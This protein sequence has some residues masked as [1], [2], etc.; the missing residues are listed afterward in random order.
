MAKRLKVGLILDGLYLPAWEYGIVESIV[1]SDIAYVDLLVFVHDADLKSRARTRGALFNF[2]EKQG[3]RKTPLEPDACAIMNAQLLLASTSSIVLPSTRR[4]P[5]DDPSNTAIEAVCSRKLDVILDLYSTSGFGWPNAVSKYGIW[6]YRHG[7]RRYADNNG[8]IVGIREVL[9]RESVLFSA[10]QCR[11][12]GSA[13]EIELYA[14]HS[15][16]HPLSFVRTRN[17]HLWKCAGFVTRKLKDLSKNGRAAMTVSEPSET[18]LEQTDRQSR[19]V[20]ARNRAIALPMVRYLNWRIRERIARRRSFDQWTLMTDLTGAGDDFSKFQVLA[21]ARDRFWA[22]PHIIVR[23]SVYYIFFEELPFKTGRGHISVLKMTEKG[24]YQPPQIVLQRPYHLSYPF[25]LE[26]RGDL[27]MIPESAENRTIEAYRCVR[28][29]DQWEFESNLMKDVSAFDATLIEFGGFWWLFA[30]VVENRGASTWDELC[31]FYSDDPLSSQWTPHPM[32]PVVSDVRSARPGG[33][34][35]IEDGQ[36]HRPSQDCS[37]RYGYGLN[38]N[39]VTELTTSS[40]KEELIRRYQPTWDRR[41]R[42]LHTINRAGSLTAIDAL[43]ARTRLN[44]TWLS[45]NGMRK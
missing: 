41:A 10:L 32:N 27:F 24:E 23:D 28:F 40:Y 12:A 13:I 7:L 17:E 1:N 36:L 2:F 44:G 35:F 16:V 8:E 25:L 5:S 6:F 14:S 34:L 31:V 39:R 3:R 22:D 29:P 38:I 43:F 42:G 30:N 45:P 20:S 19:R 18:P 9:N 37:A 11:D 33:Q 26:W 15:A 21:P 4:S